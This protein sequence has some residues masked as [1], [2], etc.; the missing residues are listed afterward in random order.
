MP[1]TRH[2]EIHFQDWSLKVSRIS[3]EDEG[4]YKCQANSHP[5]QFINI[6]LKVVGK[7]FDPLCRPTVMTGKDKVF[8]HVGRT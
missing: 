4:I 8:T 5:P 3:T 7:K 2:L 6:R 1:L